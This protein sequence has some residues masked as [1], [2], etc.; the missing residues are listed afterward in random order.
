MEKSRYCIAAMF[1]VCLSLAGCDID[2]QKESSDF[3][4][5]KETVNVNNWQ[6]RL[7]VENQNKQKGAD[8][9]G[10]RN[11]YLKATLH[12]SNTKTK[13]SLLYSISDDTEDYQVKYKFLSFG[14]K[15]DL[16]IKYKGDFIYP[17]GYVFE[18]S[19]GLAGSE[20][21][22]YKFQIDNEIY[23]KLKEDNSAVEYWYID[24]LIGLGK[25]CFTHNN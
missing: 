23:K 21:L 19:S 14:C 13:K 22:V 10:L 2:T 8:D 18:P 12:L 11:Q 16:Y 3:D 5:L 6:F 4:E 17:I 7:H 9:I 15:D 1:S 20:R 25:I 24:R